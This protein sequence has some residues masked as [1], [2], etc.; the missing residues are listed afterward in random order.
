M[1]VHDEHLESNLAERFTF[2]TMINIEMNR[3]D[4]ISQPDLINTKDELILTRHP[5]KRRGVYL[6]KEVYES[7]KTYI[8]NMLK[9]KGEVSFTQLLEQN[10]RPASND[11]LFRWLLLVVKLDLEARDLIKVSMRKDAE[12]K[13]FLRIK[14]DVAAA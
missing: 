11:T 5:E 8:L 3:G 7:T 1:N 14:R 6:S 9:E 12:I 4:M 10:G 2:E 13:Q